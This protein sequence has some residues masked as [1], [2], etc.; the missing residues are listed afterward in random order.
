ML[1]LASVRG[2]GHV[3]LVKT[4]GGVPSDALFSANL[5]KVDAVD[6]IPKKTVVDEQVGYSEH[7]GDDFVSITIGVYRLVGYLLRCVP[8]RR[9]L[10]AMHTPVRVEVDIC[11][12]V[13]S[14]FKKIASE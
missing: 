5:R 9:E 7:F 1:P 2:E 3:P 11:E 12:I 8:R 10:S 14:H 13:I 6:L 4:D